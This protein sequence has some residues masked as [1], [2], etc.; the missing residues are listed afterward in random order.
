MIGDNILAVLSRRLSFRRLPL[1]LVPPT[2][3]HQ[4]QT[5]QVIHH[6]PPTRPAPRDS[7]PVAV[8]ALE[9]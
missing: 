8:R 9:V 6:P 4:K 7:I 1:L 3:R 5:N 2:T